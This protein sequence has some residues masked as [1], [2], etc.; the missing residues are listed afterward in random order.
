[1]TTNCLKQ[2]YQDGR[3]IRIGL[4]AD[5]TAGSDLQLGMLGPLD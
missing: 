5:Y 3:I 4:V 1:M 2:N